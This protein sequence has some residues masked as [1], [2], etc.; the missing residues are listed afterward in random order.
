VVELTEVVRPMI[1]Q[2][3]LVRK[4]GLAISSSSVLSDR[5]SVQRNSRISPPRLSA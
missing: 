5:A 1:G 3:W 4:Q 2:L